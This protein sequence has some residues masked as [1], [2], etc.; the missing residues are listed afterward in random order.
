[1]K[2][3]NFLD[4]FDETVEYPTDIAYNPMPWN[5]C[6]SYISSTFLN[7]FINYVN[8]ISCYV[9]NRYTKESENISKRGVIIRNKG[10]YDW[11]KFKGTKKELIDLIVSEEK[12]MSHTDLSC[13]GDDIIVLAEIED[14]RNNKK[15]YNKFMF[16]WFDRDVSDC[17]IGRIKT[18]DYK[19]FL[20]ESLGNWLAK[21]FGDNKKHE[22]KCG[23]ES[24][25][26]KLPLSFF[27]GWVKF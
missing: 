3:K 8:P 17:S 5:V 14:E 13:F 12:E 26:H 10:E 19:E 6:W 25:F 21:E 4:Y 2:V 9:V 27:K 20:V 18:E 7:G 1:M 11:Q 16:F 23:D 22:E 24:G 15:G